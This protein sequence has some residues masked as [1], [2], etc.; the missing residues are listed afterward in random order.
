[1]A[2]VAVGE[3]DGRPIAISG[4]GDR[5]LY[6]WDLATHQPIGEPLTGHTDGVTGVAVGE[7]DGRPIAVSGSHDGTVRRWNLSSFGD[8]RTRP[9][10]F[11]RDS[12]KLVSSHSGRVTSVACGEVGQMLVVASGGDDH[13]V[14]LHRL[15]DGLPLRGLTLDAPITALV[16]APSSLLVVGTTQGLVVVALDPL[17]TVSG[18]SSRG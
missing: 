8:P 17:D 2:A 16:M 14:H 7:L 11:W 13:T 5:K 18:E 1:V 6:L 9:H 4:G 10:R 15:A 12:T 3:L